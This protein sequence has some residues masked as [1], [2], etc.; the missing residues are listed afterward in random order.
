MSRKQ[1]LTHD[2]CRKKVCFFCLQ[3]KK[4][5]DRTLSGSNIDFIIHGIFPEYE[6][7]AN[8]LLCGICNS[9][10]TRI[11]KFMSK[12]QSDPEDYQH[13]Q[14]REKYDELIEEAQSVFD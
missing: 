3:K 13:A 9:C 1:G 12:N 10:N 2:E 4:G 6:T 5:D 11:S 8:Y 14:S 7:V